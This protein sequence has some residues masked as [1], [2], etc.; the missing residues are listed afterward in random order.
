MYQAALQL[1]GSTRSHYNSPAKNLTTDY[2]EVVSTSG[3]PRSGKSQVN[4]SQG[5]GKVREFL[6]GQGK[7]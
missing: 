7:S 2:I 1:N 4:F 3:L 5:Q 6:K